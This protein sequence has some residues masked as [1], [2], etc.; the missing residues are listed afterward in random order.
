MS[1]RL[2][3]G[4]YRSCMSIL[5]LDLDNQLVVH[6]LDKIV[7]GIS[8]NEYYI[9]HNVFFYRILPSVLILPSWKGFY[10]K[11]KTLKSVNGYQSPTAQRFLS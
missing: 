7:S 5:E 3:A 10:Q 8:F 6:E 11:T 9:K 1:L 4:T 2:V